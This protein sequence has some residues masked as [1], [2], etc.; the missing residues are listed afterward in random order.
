MAIVNISMTAT[1]KRA[2]KVLAIFFLVLLLLVLLFRISV[3]SNLLH[4]VLNISSSASTSVYRAIG[5]LTKSENALILERDEY[6]ELAANLA[7]DQTHLDELERQVEE[8]SSLLSYKESVPYD[9]IVAKI[10]LRS[11]LGGQTILIDKGH[12]DGIQEN[13]AVTVENGHMVGYISSVQKNTATVTLLQSEQSRI[14]AKIVGK[15]ETNGIAVG[16]EGFLL[17]MD[18]VPQRVNMQEAD[19][20]VTSGLEGRYPQ[21]LVLGAVKTVHKDVTEAFQH[22]DIQPFYDVNNY[23]TVLI[24]NPYQ[25]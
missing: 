7:V 2:V 12:I 17:N 11:E 4:G 20:I 22:A 24:I 1:R 25:S 19:I 10:V 8:L 13:F 5:R 6:Q 23:S 3:F 14:P 15:E 16:Q 21:G 18:F 9:V